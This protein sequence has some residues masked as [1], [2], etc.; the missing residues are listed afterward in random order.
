MDLDSILSSPFGPR[1]L[2]SPASHPHLA[3][4]RSTENT[5]WSPG[6]A[7]RAP[8]LSLRVTQRCSGEKVLRSSQALVQKSL[9]PKTGACYPQVAGKAGPGCAG[10]W[11]GGRGGPG[12]LPGSCGPEGSR[13]EASSLFSA[14][15][16]RARSGV[17]GGKRLAEGPG[18]ST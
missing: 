2:I 10:D 18:S 9:V 15:P 7:P 16:P 3:R 13:K 6:Q 12:K 1:G 4:S 17:L 8:R 11:V 5:E 14:W